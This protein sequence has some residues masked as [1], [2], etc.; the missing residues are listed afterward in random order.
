[1][2]SPTF[3]L[4][5]ILGF[6]VIYSLAILI[7][8]I[9]PVSGYAIYWLACTAIGWRLAKLTPIVQHIVGAVLGFG[10]AWLHPESLAVIMIALSVFFTVVYL[11]S[12]TVRTAYTQIVSQ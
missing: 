6:S 9:E 1:M 11:R 7:G 2:R 3:S 4:F 12:E 5:G 8:Q 10:W